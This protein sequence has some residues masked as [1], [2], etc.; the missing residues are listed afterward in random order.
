MDYGT[1]SG[2]AVVVRASDGAEFG[3][4][5]HEYEHGV[6]DLVLT[7]D[8]GQALPPEWALQV[9]ADYVN[10]LKKAV[11]AAAGADPCDVVGIGTDFTAC[12]MVP[13]TADGT[14]LCE[15]DEFA[16]RPHAYVKLW[17]YHAAVVV[18]LYP[19][20]RAAARSMGKRTVAAYTLD[21]D[22]AL[23]Y[24]AFLA[25]YTALH[26]YFGRGGND[27]MRRLKRIRR[28]VLATQVGAGAEETAGAVR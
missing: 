6:M 12:T 26:D 28:E 22:A 27:V 5:V 24:D 18:G 20:V 3:S 9:L 23:R 17:K 7:A 4:A 1:L 16:D 21:E 19:E 25:E 15:L 2:R 14:P 13:A 8:Q 11:P 10:V